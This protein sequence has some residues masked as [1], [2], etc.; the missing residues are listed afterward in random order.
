MDARTPPPHNPRTF[1][2]K[3]LRDSRVVKIDPADRSAVAW[4]KAR[5]AQLYAELARLIHDCLARLLED[6]RSA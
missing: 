2:F 5:I 3:R 1:V 4:A 6:F